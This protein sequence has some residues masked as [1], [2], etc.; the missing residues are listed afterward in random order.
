M[1][2]YSLFLTV[3]SV[4]EGPI[5]DVNLCRPFQR[6]FRLSCRPRFAPTLCLGLGSQRLF[7]CPKS[8]DK[9]LLKNRRKDGYPLIYIF[10]H[11]LDL[12]TLFKPLHKS[13]IS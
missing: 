2:F 13:I 10:I 7:C 5:V 9:V 3:L 6:L 12:Y 4:S 8:R 1:L 11:I